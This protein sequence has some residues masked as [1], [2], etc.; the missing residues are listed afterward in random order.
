MHTWGPCPQPAGIIRNNAV[1]G[2]SLLHGGANAIFGASD[3]FIYSNYVANVCS[4]SHSESDI[5]N[6]QFTNTGIPQGANILPDS[7]VFPGN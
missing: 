3:S 7:L 2:N 6:M 4:G 5:T 1:I